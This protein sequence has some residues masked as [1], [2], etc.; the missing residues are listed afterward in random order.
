M[1][2]MMSLSPY[3]KFGVYKW[4]WGTLASQRVIYYDELRVG[5]ANSSYDEVKP[6]GSISI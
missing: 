4:E 1:P 6:G 2:I 3:F 5:N